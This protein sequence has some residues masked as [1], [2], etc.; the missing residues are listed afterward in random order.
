MP[1]VV[2]GEL[3]PGK[4][5]T[6]VVDLDGVVYL[7][8]VGITGAADALRAI[9]DAGFL[10]LFATNNSTK[11]PQIAA[12]HIRTRTGFAADSHFIVTSAQAAASYLQGR[13]GTALV[14]GAPAIG[15]ALAEVGVTAVTNWDDAQ[16]VVVGLDRS[17]TYERLA[18][19]T[20]AVRRGNALLVATNDDA[21][22]PTPEGLLPGGG[23][24]VAAVERATGVAAV[25][26]G[27]PHLPMR[28]LI[29]ERARGGILMV[30]DRLET[31]IALAGNDWQSALVLSGVTQAAPG[32]DATYRP[33]VV[34]E[35]IAELPGL[36]GV[37]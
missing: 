4:I 21:T 32:S 6:I 30:G 18:A 37:S 23:A 9:R 22:Y 10:L 36:L 31:D 3:S 17:F 20:R 2:A 19:A 16:A 26:T 14:V 34:I 5:G 12:D 35:S 1:Q 33:S 24:I 11:T 29:E 7:D 8:S 15:E 13:C 27:K 28:R 25:V